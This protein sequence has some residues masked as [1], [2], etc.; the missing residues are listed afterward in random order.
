[1][2]HNIEFLTDKIRTITDNI[3]GQI[4]QAAEEYAASLGREGDEYNEDKEYALEYL[5][6]KIH[7][8]Q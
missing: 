6:S 1:M 3:E 5:N 2:E 4:E 8:N 7:V